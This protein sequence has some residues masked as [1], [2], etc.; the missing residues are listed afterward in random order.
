M[1]DLL[2]LNAAWQSA[3]GDMRLNADMAPFF[4]CC[5]TPETWSILNRLGKVKTSGEFMQRI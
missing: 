3:I 2:E 5:G 4:T 1:R